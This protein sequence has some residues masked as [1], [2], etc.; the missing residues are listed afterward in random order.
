MTPAP[1]KGVNDRQTDALVWAALLAGLGLAFAS[2][3]AWFGGCLRYGIWGFAN[4]G[5]TGWAIASG[6]AVAALSCAAL[7]YLLPRRSGRLLDRGLK[8]LG[9]AS[10]AVAAASA[11]ALPLGSP[12]F[13]W[14][15]LDVSWL[16]I[17]L[18]LVGVTTREPPVAKSVLGAILGLTLVLWGLLNFASDDPLPIIGGAFFAVPFAIWSWRFASRVTNGWL[19]GAGVQ[20]NS[21]LRRVLN[22]IIVAGVAVFIVLPL[23]IVSTFGGPVIGDPVD[24]YSVRN[25]T[26]Q[27]V[28]FEP[29]RGRA[30]YGQTIGPGQ[31]LDTGSFP[32]RHDFAANI[33]GAEIWCRSYGTGDLKRMRFLIVIVMDPASCR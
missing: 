19:P 9:I 31:T 15:V 33:G 28:Q 23:W 21:P 32:S 18:W 6:Y 26:G 13:V 2:A 10:G 27:T 1:L 17:G 3:Y 24:P 16:A 11:I 22:D 8:P 25:D 14:R 7:A 30:E 29:V 5:Y 12:E 20:R 4:C